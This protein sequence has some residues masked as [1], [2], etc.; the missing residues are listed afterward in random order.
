M[1]DIKVQMV[2]AGSRAGQ[3]ERR[4]NSNNGR[5]QQQRKIIIIAGNSAVL[6]PSAV[7]KREGPVREEKERERREI[8]PLASKLS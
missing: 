7:N 2:V 1:L 5:K 8:W 4:G 3:E 6:F